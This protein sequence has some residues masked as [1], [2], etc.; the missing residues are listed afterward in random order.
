MVD[1]QGVLLLAKVNEANKQDGE[2]CLKMFQEKPFQSLSI[3]W[4]DSAY[5]RAFLREFFAT[6]GIEL[7]IVGGGIKEGY[8]IEKE[9]LKELQ[10]IPKTFQVQPRRWVVERTLAW[11]NRN[12]RLSKDYEYLTEVSE[13]YMYAGMARILLKRMVKN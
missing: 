11:L 2:S 4:A 8:W 12:R 13:S 6:F 3:I 5:R 7:S 9:K 1:T 10:P